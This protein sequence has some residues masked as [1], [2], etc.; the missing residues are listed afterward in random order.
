MHGVQLNGLKSILLI[1]SH[2]LAAPTAAKIPKIILKL[3]NCC[4]NIRCS[5]ARKALNFA[6]TH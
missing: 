4:C 5:D 3:F 2:A 6:V 1:V